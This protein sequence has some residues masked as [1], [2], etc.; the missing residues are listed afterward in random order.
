MYKAKCK[1]SKLYFSKSKGRKV[2]ASFA[3]GDITSDAGSLLLREA[4]KAMALTD[5]LAPLFPDSRNPLYI[6][7]SVKTMLKQRLYGLALGYEDLNDHDTLRGDIALQT[8]TDSSKKLASSSTLCR[9]ENTASRELA[10]AVSR[11]LVELFIQSHRTPP[12]ELVLDFDATDDKI[13]GKQEKGA[14]HG[15]YRHECFLPLYVTC[16]SHVLVSYLRPCSNDQA[17]HAWPILA[18]LVKRLRQAWPEVRI[19]FS[20]RFGILPTSSLW[21]V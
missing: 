9:L 2:E 1:S 8:A 6:T 10:V 16:G 15:Y 7:H 13:H 4:D 18:L 11:Q 21:L 17:L 5:Q 19:I 14:Y 20:S 3:G 12:E